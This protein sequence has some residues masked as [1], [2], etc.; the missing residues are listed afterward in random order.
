MAPIDVSIAESTSHAIGIS[1]NLDNGG[2][3]TGNKGYY[4][5]DPNPGT[6]P[7]AFVLTPHKYFQGY[8]T[9]ETRWPLIMGEEGGMYDKE[10]HP[11][12][13]R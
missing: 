1:L 11:M 10:A 7:P 3:A 5:I 13:Q 8:G 9:G 6:P 4:T 12:E 2:P